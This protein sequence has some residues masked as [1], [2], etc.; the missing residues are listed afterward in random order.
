MHTFFSVALVAATA[1]AQQDFDLERAVQKNLKWIRPPTWDAMPEDMDSFF[2]QSP[3][4]AREHRRSPRAQRDHYYNE[5]DHEASEHDAHEALRAKELRR[6]KEYHQEHDE[7]FDEPVYH[8]QQTGRWPD[9]D[10]GYQHYRAHDY[11]NDHGYD[12]DYDYDRHTYAN[13]SVY[14]H[15]YEKD[16]DSHPAVFGDHLTDA[17][18][19][20]IEVYRPAAY[21]DQFLEYEEVP[22]HPMSNGGPRSNDE[23]DEHYDW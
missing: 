7:R 9:E 3:S 1:C 15:V 6:L 2:K 22:H 19:Y 16:Y 5:H 11:Y 13:E 4:E 17:D 20:R 14:D 10:R 8:H 12:H 23:N 21:Y 18:G